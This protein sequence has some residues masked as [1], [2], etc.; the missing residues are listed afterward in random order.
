MPV[1]QLHLGGG[2]DARGAHFGRQVVKIVA[3]R[4]PDA[5]VA[6]LRLYTARKEGDE[7]PAN[8]DE[9]IDP[10]SVLAALGEIATAPIRPE[11]SADIGEETGFLVTNGTGECAA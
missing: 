6:L 8:F 2:V 7:T 10:K 3:R 5:V 4:V 11:E 1:Y 9:R